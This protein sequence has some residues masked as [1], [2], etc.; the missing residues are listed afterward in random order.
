MGQARIRENLYKRYGKEK[1]RER[2]AAY[3]ARVKANLAREAIYLQIIQENKLRREQ[4][5]ENRTA[6]KAGTRESY[7]QRKRRL[8]KERRLAMKSK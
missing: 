8:N 2:I 4:S 3:E 7:R 5:Y 6:I 1:A